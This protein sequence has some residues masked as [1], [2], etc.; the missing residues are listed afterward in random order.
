MRNAE[1]RE[2]ELETVEIYPR[3]TIARWL[4]LVIEKIPLF[5]LAA[6][7]CVV[8]VMVQRA[9]GAVRSAADVPYGLRLLNVVTA[10]ARYA[11]WTFW[12]ANLCVY[13]LLPAVAPVVPALAA[14]AGLALVSWLVFRW[15]VTKPWLMVG[16]FWFLGT[17]VPVIGFV[18]V[19]SQAMAD[20]YTYIPLIGLFIALVWGLE[21]ELGNGR[22]ARIFG[23]ALA[24][25]LLLG[26]L[27]VTRHQLGFWR[28][29]ISL[30]QR[31]AAVAQ[32]N[33]FAEHE[34]GTAL[35][36]AGRTTEAIMHHEASLRI[37]PAYEPAHY[38]LGL[39][40]E[41][42]GRLDDAS[43]QFLAALARDPA[44]EQ[45]H[46][47]LGVVRAQQERLPE[48]VTEFRKAIE[49]NPAY[50]SA[51]LNCGN[52][53]GKLGETGPSLE[54]LRKARELEP[55]SALVLNQLAL[56]LAT[57]TDVKW[58][59]PAEAVTLAEK[60]SELAR[61]QSSEC[62]AT[63]AKAHAAAG[64]F[65]KAATTAEKALAQ[66]REQKL[67]EMVKSLEQDLAAYR[68]GQVSGR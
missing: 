7:A 17:L 13:Y 25:A 49:L 12:P 59:N 5:A 38:H 4:P 57:A 8:T 65:S 45:L 55:E 36:N 2:G 56:L 54:N 19:G 16:W 61:G 9:G 27:A 52:A 64:D 63:L 33:Y 43:L 10:Y 53:L 6:G 20:R 46:N 22:G 31:A 66:A 50:A 44:S 24:G 23:G 67:P 14:G 29:D 60:A 62:L 47:A 15:R 3:G 39:E 30:W 58:R 21:H 18:Q 68:K 28:D 32:D 1:L 42:V 26:C 48:A 34:L 40:L 51:Y 41:A 35:A 11:G 37:N